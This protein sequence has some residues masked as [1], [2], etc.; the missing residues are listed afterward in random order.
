[1]K[2]VLALLLSLVSSARAQNA[3]LA[4]CH[5]PQVCGSNGAGQYLVL[6]A[7]GNIPASIMNASIPSDAPASLNVAGPGQFGAGAQKSTISASGIQVPA[8]SSITVLTGPL[9]VAIAGGGNALI[10]STNGRTNYN[11][12][13]ATQAAGVAGDLVTVSCPAGKFEKSGGCSCTGTAIGVETVA[14][15]MPYPTPTVGGNMPTGW[16]CQKN[17]ATAGLACAA[18]VECWT[19]SSN[20]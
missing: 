4:I 18:F 13:F 20:P 10:V 5:A 17:D 1:M 16:Q 12:S 8:G 3:D 9:Y 11:I 15:S 7:S 14:I 6:D 2:F 19:V